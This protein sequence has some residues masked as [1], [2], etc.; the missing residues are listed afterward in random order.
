MAQTLEER[1]ASAAAASRRWRA[2]HPDRAKAIERQAYHRRQAQE[3]R[4]SHERR[5]RTLEEKRAQSRER[6]RR[7]RQ[8]NPE[9]YHASVQA[10]HEKYKER[11]RAKALAWY[12]R[13]RTKALARAKT[14]NLK[15]LYCLTVEEKAAL[16]DRCAICGTQPTGRG[17]NGILHVDH[18]HETAHH[19]L[20]N[21]TAFDIYPIRA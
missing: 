1:R 21:A 6:T 9:A 11:N 7:W 10:T 3:G 12:R 19:Y 2:K 13:N 20:L 17:K 14:Y 5:P 15:R 4:T 16:G 18:D 8:N